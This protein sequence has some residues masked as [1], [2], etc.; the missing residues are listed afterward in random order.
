MLEL[1]FNE[2]GCW[3]GYYRRRY[4]WVPAGGGAEMDRAVG[5]IGEPSAREEMSKVGGLVGKSA[6]KEQA[7]RVRWSYCSRSMNLWNQW[8][9][10]DMLNM[11]IFCHQTM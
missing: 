2:S 11:H 6:A 8:E 10:T 3:S 7:S 1:F 9:L 4:L 5:G